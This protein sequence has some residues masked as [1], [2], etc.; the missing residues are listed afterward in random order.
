MKEDLT[1]HQPDTTRKETMKEK[2]K[3]MHEDNKTETETVK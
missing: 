3:G 1:A 2:V